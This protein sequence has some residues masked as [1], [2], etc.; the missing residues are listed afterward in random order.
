MVIASLIKHPDGLISFLSAI[1][2]DAT[3]VGFIAIIHPIRF[4]RERGIP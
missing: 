4:A 1:G 2:R 3:K